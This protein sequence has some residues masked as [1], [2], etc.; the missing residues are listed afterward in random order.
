MLITRW[1]ATAVLWAL[2]TAPVALAQQSTPIADAGKLPTPAQKSQSMWPRILP[3]DKLGETPAAATPAWSPGEIEQARARCT[4]LLKGLDVVA[5]PLTPVREGTECGAPAPMQL[6]SIG[7]SPQIAFSPPP[8]LTCDMIAALH[9]WLE[10]EVQPLAR[11]HLGAPIVGVATMSSFSCRTAYGRANSRLSEHG[12]VNALDIGAF[13]TA[14]GQTAMVIADWGPIARDIAARAVAAQ[15]GAEKKQGGPVARQDN[16]V[17]Q[18]IAPSVVQPPGI[19][20]EFP[21]MI[22]GEPPSGLTTGLGWAPPSRVGG[23]KPADAP[24]PG[25]ANGKTLFLHAA[26][27]AACRIFATVL[28]PEANKAHRNHFHLDM[29]ERKSA[30][31]C[32]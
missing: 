30:T 19:A 21:G 28:G 26:H 22:I 20:F 3:Q 7:S 15:A 24:P 11:K 29:A 2:A 12:R 23:P 9:R 14:Q 17:P 10:R 5:I 25:V 4:E 8:M 32:E 27:R 16:K 13:L 1:A 6:F 31:I 18:R